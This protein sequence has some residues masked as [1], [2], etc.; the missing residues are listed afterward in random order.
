MEFVIDYWD[1]FQ[2]VFTMLQILSASEQVAA[3]LLREL[4]SGRW[5]D[6]MPG[7]LSLV[8]ELGSHGTMNLA[9]VIT[10]G[11]C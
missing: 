1:K 5:T 8:V 10:C 9:R 6:T 3:H 4:Q 11:H 7:E 2:Q